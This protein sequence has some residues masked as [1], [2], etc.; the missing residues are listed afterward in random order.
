MTCEIVLKADKLGRSYTLFRS[1]RQRLNQLLFGKFRQFGREFWALR[2]V[3]FEVAKGESVGIIGRNGSGKSTLLQLAAGILKPS[4]GSIATQG[5]IAALLELG[6]GFDPEFTGRENVY[7]NASLLGL[8]REEVEAKFQSIVDFSEMRDFIDQPVKTY[9]SGMFVRLAFSVQIHAEPDILIVDEALSVGDVFFQQKCMNH[10]RRM[11]DRGI[12]LFFVSH[13]IAAVKSLCSKAALLEHGRLVEFGAAEVVCSSYQNS[14]SRGSPSSSSPG[15]GGARHPRLSARDVDQLDLSAF[16]S[17]L[18]HRSGSGEV[19]F[20]EVRVLDSSYTEA[21]SFGPTPT[22]V[23]EAVFAARV[24]VAA[25]AAIGVLIRDSRG[26]DVVGINSDFFDKELPALE[27]GGRYVWETVIELPLSR[28]VYSVHVGIKPQPMGS[29]FYDRCFN[30]G[31]F[32]IEMN[33]LSYS[34]YTGLLI[35]SPKSLS[36]RVL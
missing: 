24:S 22:I 7:M 18:S 12:T 21:K 27:E 29:D 14:E 19:E 28:G 15:L 32:E 11:L 10:I 20:M 2:D 8:P 23:I 35:A 33:P 9:S 17:R 1:P 4:E 26:V 13:S 3:S 5:R 16:R 6:A 30:A 36:L 34:T 31:V 25:G